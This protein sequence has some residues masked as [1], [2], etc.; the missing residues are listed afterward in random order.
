MDA[1]DS[2]IEE[3]SW[4]H[5]PSGEGRYPPSWP[6]I[7]VPTP[8][9]YIEA[10]IL[11]WIHTKD[12]NAELY[13]FFKIYDMIFAFFNDHHG[14]HMLNRMERPSGIY[15]SHYWTIVTT[16]TI[17]L[18]ISAGKPRLAYEIYCCKQ[19]N[20]CT[21]GPRGY[22][23]SIKICVGRTRF[24]NNTLTMSTTTINKEIYIL[25]RVRKLDLESNRTL[26]IVSFTSKSTKV[27]P[28]RFVSRHENSICNQRKA[29]SYSV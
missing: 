27:Y 13:W 14:L 18:G 4:H 15:G 9:H 2:D 7:K 3:G 29:D 26:D 6:R 22:R 11:H 12:T 10:L 24:A 19:R 1:S 21:T 25:D 16:R 5:D 23:D 17:F 28:V 8:Q 20:C